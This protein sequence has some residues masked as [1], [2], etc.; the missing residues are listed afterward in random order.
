[1]SELIAVAYPDQERAKE[2][3]HA[4]QRMRDEHLLELEDAVYVTK[5]SAGKVDL[6]QTL[7][8]TGAGALAGSFWGLLIGLLFFAPVAGLALGAA[9]GAL[10]GKLTDLGIKDDFIRSLSAEM[11]PG[12]SAI[13]ALVREVTVDKVLQELSRYGGTVLHTSLSAD[14][15]AKLQ[16]ALAA[17]GP[18]AR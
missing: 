13:F 9:G 14:A 3:I 15:E 6:H 16:A 17:G 18:V 11:K 1:M 5:D 7:G 4:L 10:A 2:V 8:A 12:S